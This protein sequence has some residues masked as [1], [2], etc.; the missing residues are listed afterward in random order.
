LRTYTTIA[1]GF[2]KIGWSVGHI[3]SEGFCARERSIVKAPQQNFVIGSEIDLLQIQPTMNHAI[4]VNIPEDKGKTIDNING[5]Y[6]GDLGASKL[7]MQY[8]VHPV[9][10]KVKMKHTI[11]IPHLLHLGKGENAANLMG[12]QIIYGIHIPLDAPNKILIKPHS[13]TIVQSILGKIN[14]FVL[15]GKWDL[16]MEHCFLNIAGKSFLEVVISGTRCFMPCEV[17]RNAEISKAH[18]I[19]LLCLASLFASY[20]QSQEKSRKK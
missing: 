3:F 10:F 19:N 20:H 18:A 16:I 8:G 9:R 13:L 14:C 15:F 11:F 12:S 1:K 5:S 17:L 7:L 4:L 6:S 2:G